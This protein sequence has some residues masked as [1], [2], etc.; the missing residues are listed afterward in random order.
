[1]VA[2]GYRLQAA[3]DATASALTLCDD[4]R[5][6][7][8]HP[9]TTRVQDNL[10]RSDRHVQTLPEN[11][12]VARVM[13][14]PPQTWPADAV[15]RAAKAATRQ[16]RAVQV[17]R[18]EGYDWRFAFEFRSRPGSDLETIPLRGDALPGHR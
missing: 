12:Q 11:Y 4:K 16:I 1:M 15:T 14:R 17:A 10:A 13:K 18:C 6:F 8:Y 5:L 9:T 2:Y 7:V 3:V